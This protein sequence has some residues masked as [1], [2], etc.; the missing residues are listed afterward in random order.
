MKY[1][2]PSLAVMILAVVACKKNGNDEDF[3]RTFY[4]D[5]KNNDLVLGMKKV[6]NLT[7]SFYFQLDTKDQYNCDRYRI[8]CSQEDDGKTLKITCGNIIYENGFCTYGSFPATFQYKSPKLTEGSYRI[9]VKK[10]TAEF[11][12]ELKVTANG[13]FFDWVHDEHG[14]KIDPKS[15]PR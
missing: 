11:E 15:F 5:V 7:D 9:I 6:H 10:N 12:G 1:L 8:N 14:A 4:F 3:V 2:L 13:Y